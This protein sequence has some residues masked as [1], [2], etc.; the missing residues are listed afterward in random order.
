MKPRFSPEYIGLK[1][2]PQDA[3][4]LRE[5]TWHRHETGQK[6]YARS[7][8]NGRLVYL[9]RLILNATSKQ[10]I[11]HINGD[12][13]DNRRENIR[14]ASRCLNN[15]NR[16][17]VCGVEKH[18]TKWRARIWFRGSRVELGSFAVKRQA[19]FAYQCAREQ[20]I[21]NQLIQSELDLESVGLPSHNHYPSLL[22]TLD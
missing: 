6:V 10:E 19:L 8:I 20:F 12:G 9:H 18:G 1:V 14:L 5:H 15:L 7:R 16:L 3:H 4:L 22:Q 2:S 21:I 17:G 13:L 11:D